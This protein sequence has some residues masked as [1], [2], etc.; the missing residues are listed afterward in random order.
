MKKIVLIVFMITRVIT[1][2]S[3][4][5]FDLG[6]GGD[7]INF[8]NS[9]LYNHVL[10]DTNNIWQITRPQK[11]ILFLPDDSHGIITD[12]NLYYQ[13]GV[14]SYFQFKLHL[15]RGS[16]IYNIRFW[17]KYDFNPNIDG[18]IIETSWNGGA[19][20]QNILFD[21]I[22]IANQQYGFSINMYDSTDTIRAFD[23]QPGFT[24]LQAAGKIVSFDLYSYDILYDT[25]LFRFT[26]KSDSLGGSH[27]GW[28]LDDFSFGGAV[29]DVEQI[30]HD[31]KLKIS[32]NPARE[33]VFLRLENEAISVVQL[34]TMTGVK[35]R[36]Y[37]D[38]SII[39][40]RGLTS[41]IYI[42]KVNHEYTEKLIIE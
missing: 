33:Q 5:S 1:G 37:N 30:K 21:S 22:I 11:N 18:G 40:L 15:L 42:L 34:Y 32:S 19:T 29:V 2:Y 23:N 17:H 35:T 4:E 8:E 6:F 26:F 41:G 31:K 20:W 36:E 28:L 27:E 7:W 14:T 12:T 38:T 10:I 3:Q 16:D 13:T 25:L 24:G 9:H 39:D